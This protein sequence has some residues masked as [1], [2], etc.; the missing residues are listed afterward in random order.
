MHDY[1]NEFTNCNM[2]IIKDS[3]YVDNKLN[4]GNYDMLGEVS[5]HSWSGLLMSL[6]GGGCKTV[7]RARFLCYRETGESV[8]KNEGEEEEEA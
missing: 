3:P 4:R 8:S 6:P 1:Y 5:W 7:A 2:I